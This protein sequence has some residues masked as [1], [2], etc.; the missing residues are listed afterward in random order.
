MKHDNEDRAASYFPAIEAK[1]GR[2]ISRWKAL[3]RKTGLR[4]HRELVDWLKREHG[5]GHGYATAITAH[6]LA[7]SAPTTVKRS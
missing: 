7:E 4:S 3:M 2:T 6:L 1:S 5:F